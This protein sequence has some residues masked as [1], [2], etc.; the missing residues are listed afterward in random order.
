[1]LLVIET[2]LKR[3]R[4]PSR[5]LSFLQDED[6]EQVLI[7]KIIQILSEYGKATHGHTMKVR[8]YFLTTL[9]KKPSNFVISSKYETSSAEQLL[10]E[11]FENVEI[12]KQYSEKIGVAIA[13]EGYYFNRNLEHDI[14]KMLA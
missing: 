7:K 4:T 10:Q 2:L 9:Q 3:Y 5:V 6:E 11:S 12:D 13:G 14:D 1:M 8:E